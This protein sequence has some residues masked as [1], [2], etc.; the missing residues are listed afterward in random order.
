VK[1]FKLLSEQMPRIDNFVLN[2]FTNLIQS[3]AIQLPGKILHFE[4]SFSDILTLHEM[5]LGLQISYDMA[6]VVPDVKVIS[7]A[8]K[9]DLARNFYFTNQAERDHLLWLEEVVNGLVVVEEPVGLLQS[10]EMANLVH[11]ARKGRSADLLV[12]NLLPKFLYL[13]TSFI[14]TDFMGNLDEIRNIQLKE[15]LRYRIS[16]ICLVKSPISE[17]ISLF[18]DFLREPDFN[19]S[20]SLV[21][22]TKSMLTFLARVKAML[23][24]P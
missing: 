10:E 8:I 24:S 7:Q 20:E 15:E 3:H 14:L 22:F 12:S 21:N 23:G 16:R 11:F 4:I 9:I 13:V 6:K 17:L 2:D 5:A 1:K 18:R 19:V